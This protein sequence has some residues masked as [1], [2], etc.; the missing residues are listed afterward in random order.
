MPE[1]RDV[2][3]F[4]KRFAGGVRMVAGMLR[5][6]GKRPVLVSAVPDDINRE[7]CDVHVVV[8]WDTA[9]FPQFIE[10]IDRAGVVPTA[11]V[12]LVEPLLPWQL[13]VARH[14]G[15]P[16]G[17]PAR[18]V[19]LSKASVRTEMA[20]I[21]QSS[22]WFDNGPAG[23]VD[24][25]AVTKFP[26]IVKPARDSGGS[27]LVR[28]ANDTEQLRT[29][30][31]AMA[32]TAGPD[33]EVIIEEYLDG[34]EFSVDG[35]V[36]D[37][38]FHALFSVEKPE[39]D[40][41]R[42]HDA[43]LRLSPPQSDAVRVA[44]EQLSAKVSALCTELGLQR[45]WF[46]VEGRALPDG[47]AELV[48]IN[49]RSGGGLYRSATMR[50][51]GLD[52][53]EVTV[54]MALGEEDVS[55]LSTCTRSDE[56][57]GM[58]PFEVNQLGRVVEATSLDEIKAIPGVVDGYQFD[59]FEVTSLDNE[60]FY[61]EAL[62][63]G[64]S[65]AHLQEIAD[66]VRSAFHVRVDQ[67]SGEHAPSDAHV[68]LCK[69]SPTL[70]RSLL[71]IT[72]H[73]YVV[74]DEYDVKFMDPDWDMLAEAARVYRISDFDSNEEVAAVAADLALREVK[75]DHVISW[76]EFSQFGAG[77]L[78][79]LLGLTTDPLKHVSFRDKRMMKQR[80]GGT[81]VPTARWM[82]LPDRNSESDRQA[83]RDGLRFPVV[84][85][86]AAGSGTIG[87]VTVHRPE[88]LDGALDALAPDPELR[89][90]QLIAE[91]RIEGR[92]LHVDALWHG[93]EPLYFVI[94]AY[95]KPRL[96]LVEDSAA[97]VPVTDG[98]IDG[99]Y[100]LPAEDSP[101]LYR[102][103][104]QLHRAVNQAMGI[105][106]GA[107]HLEVFERADGELVFSEIATRLGGAWIGQVLSEYLGYEV[108]TAL[109][110]GTVRGAIDRPRPATSHLGALQLR[111]ATSGR[112][113][114]MPSEADMRAFDGVLRAQKLRGVGDDVDL[115]H[116][117]NWC[118]F[119]VLGAESTDAYF[120]V[121]RRIIRGLR[122]EVEA[123]G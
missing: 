59:S 71:D 104:L 70:T 116:P 92:E 50:T 48:E 109:A 51:C 31:S 64:E 45:G 69:W 29:C 39:H 85:K 60:N 122:V 86:P 37:G 68:V 118:G 20:R 96:A 4:S 42:H 94:S 17:E 11:V 34:T 76:T 22:L 25:E 41:E 54:G 91:E 40:E 55:A 105:T 8:D 77:Y 78:E 58:L 10:A 110:S 7:S 87:T 83:V 106:S 75:V 99:S 72:P 81:D 24:A 14:Y 57:L 119:V 32:Q 79:V 5:D 88:D 73:V 30:L 97:N 113:T 100:V 16:G 12:N 13:Q 56:L 38:V 63:S 3:V 53:V 108:H 115:T 46:H 98:P 102:R 117:S 2:L 19:L 93:D 112:I 28:R 67:P 101:D 36:V 82:T 35:P 114:R 52:P 95:Y 80:L 47:S 43:G 66:R 1:S 107:T 18:D 111:P 44:V 123:T 89:S 49:P 26:V 33:L 61:T 6:R 23:L 9:D 27:R 62:L 103:A 65:V 120:D 21:G 74:L 121:A 90:V 15:L 84:I